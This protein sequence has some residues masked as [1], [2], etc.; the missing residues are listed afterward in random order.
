V[1]TSFFG[2]AFFGGE[3]YSVTAVVA[4]QTPAGRGGKSKGSK[5][6]RF[7]VWEDEPEEAVEAP[8]V[9]TAPAKVLKAVIRA[10][11]SGER[12]LQAMRFA[13]DDGPKLDFAGFLE[14]MRAR[15]ILYAAK[16]EAALLRMRREDAEL[17]SVLKYLH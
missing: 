10:R 3:F 12:A 15:D 5:R 17:V 9:V 4:T 11:R 16:M 8:I 2:G 13:V 14:D 7:T 1:S 6:P